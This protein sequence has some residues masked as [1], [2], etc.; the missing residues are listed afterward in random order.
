MWIIDK[1]EEKYASVECSNIFFDIPIAALPD[2]AKKGDVLDV[3]INADKRAEREKIIA[4]KMN[5]L[6]NK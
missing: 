5:R 1:I 6:F 4:D 3:S 2:G